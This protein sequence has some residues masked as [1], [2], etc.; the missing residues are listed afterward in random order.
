MIEYAGEM[1][2]FQENKMITEITDSHF[3]IEQLESIKRELDLISDY[4]QKLL[5]L[6]N[7]SI[8]LVV[9]R[10]LRAPGEEI[11]IDLSPISLDEIAIYNTTV[12]EFLQTAHNNNKFLNYKHRYHSLD[13]Y[14][15][16]FNERCR[17]G[18]T[19]EIIKSDLEEITDTYPVSQEYRRKRNLDFMDSP[20]ERYQTRGGVDVFNY[21]QAGH[22]IDYKCKYISTRHH[23]IILQCEA[24]LKYY[25][26]LTDKIKTLPQPA[27][28]N[29]IYKEQDNSGI[30]EIKQ[31]VEKVANDVTKFIKSQV[32]AKANNYDQGQSEQILN[33]KIVI[34]NKHQKLY[35]DLILNFNFFQKI[36]L[37]DLIANRDYEEFI[38]LVVEEIRRVSDVRRE[39][40]QEIHYNLEKYESK[41]TRFAYLKRIYLKLDD[42][43]NY[44]KR[45]EA[46]INVTLGAQF[47]MTEEER[48]SDRTLEEKTRRVLDLKRKDN[49]AYTLG[50]YPDVTKQITIPTSWAQYYVSRC[51]VDVACL[52]IALRRNAEVDGYNLGKQGNDASGVVEKIVNQSGKE[53]QGGLASATQNEVHQAPTASINQY[54][55]LIYIKDDI[56]SLLHEALT[57]LF[58]NC[59]N[60]LVLLKG[61]KSKTPIQFKK[62][63]KQLCSIFKY[64]HNKELIRN[65]LEEVRKWVINSFTITEKEKEK[66]LNSNTVDRYFKDNI[67]VSPLKEFEY[68]DKK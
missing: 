4:K 46:V 68:L 55:K 3:T 63:A 48:S 12:R 22:K 43:S 41:E 32:S 65:P 57:P 51:L 62:K 10:V 6:F 53:N 1:L 58:Y 40:E 42:I 17:N 64:L 18:I 21:L 19:E 31:T 28:P 5:T 45:H 20:Y 44:C 37:N 7:Y 26:F 61:E 8:E 52:M 33:D 2:P 36:H 16:Y 49:S 50:G 38:F 9:S 34:K 47:E 29:V 66:P 24:V 54:Q 59:Q 25:K 13:D 60:L 27:I 56:V 15:I 14:L 67:P 35:F 11:L 39:F 23:I 30:K